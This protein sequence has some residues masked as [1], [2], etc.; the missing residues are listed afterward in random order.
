MCEARQKVPARSPRRSAVARP[1]LWRHS[2]TPRENIYSGGPQDC[3][4][5]APE[6]WTP[7]DC[8]RPATR[9]CGGADSAVQL[10][11]A[12]PTSLK[13]RCG[14]R[15]YRFPRQLRGGG[16]LLPLSSR[17]RQHRAPP[18]EGK[19]P[20]EGISTSNMYLGPPRPL[21]GTRRHLGPRR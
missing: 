12:L 2:M 5:T 20:T 15:R 11:P 7:A 16:S 6:T 4:R 21:P 1:Q 9:K 18:A 13:P 19:I 8:S 14:R 10:N 3:K 17:R